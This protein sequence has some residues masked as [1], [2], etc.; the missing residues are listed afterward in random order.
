MKSEDIC[1]L[2]GKLWQTQCA[3]K[4]RHYSANNGPYSQSYGLPSGHTWLW[5]LDH[6]EGKAL[7]NW[8]LQTVMLEKMPESSLDSKES[9]SVHLKGNQPWILT[10]RTDA[11]AQTPVF[12]SSDAN[13]W[14]TGKVPDA[15]TDGGQ[16]E[17]RASEEEMAGWHHWYNEQELG[18]TLGDGDGQ[19][20][21]HARVAKSQTQ[22]GKQQ[23]Q[24]LP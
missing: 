13:S 15:G 24:Q 4:Q 9:K 23:Q 10:G 6:K 17:K 22:L 1:F 2:A 16:K 8:C 12:W 11:E 7:K 21:W 5:Q 18:Q 14:L 3:E 20:G 19:G